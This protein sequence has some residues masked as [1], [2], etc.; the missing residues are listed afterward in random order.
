MFAGKGA[1]KAFMMSLRSLGPRIFSILPWT[2][3][4]IL[5]SYGIPALQACTTHQM[6]C[7]LW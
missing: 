6:P 4:L 2:P 1:K 5:S 3:A 7:F